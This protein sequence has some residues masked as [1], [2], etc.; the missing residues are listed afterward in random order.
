MR[1][2]AKIHRARRQHDPHADRNC[3]QEADA[4]TAC[5]TAVSVLVSTPPAIRILAHR[6]QSRSPPRASLG[7]GGGGMSI[8]TRTT[9]ADQTFDRHWRNTRAYAA[10]PGALEIQRHRQMVFERCC[11]PAAGARIATDIIRQAE[12]LKP[13]APS[14]Y[15]DSPPSRA[16]RQPKMLGPST[17]PVRKSPGPLYVGSRTLSLREL[18]TQQKSNLQSHNGSATLSGMNGTLRGRRLWASVAQPRNS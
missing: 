5:S 6:Y 7:A 1:A 11:A 3:D 8:G 9:L 18:K 10:R 12:L 16:L 13:A 14:S 4:F 15:P 2:A 17:R